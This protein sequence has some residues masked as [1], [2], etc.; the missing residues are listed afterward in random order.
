MGTVQYCDTG[1]E[2]Y[3][4]ALV[5]FVTYI[6]HFNM[7]FFISVTFSY[8]RTKAAYQRFVRTRVTNSRKSFVCDLLLSDLSELH[9]HEPFQRNCIHQNQTSIDG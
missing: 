9:K 7:F 2:K 4:A 1:S 8:L 6:K 5:M 3:L